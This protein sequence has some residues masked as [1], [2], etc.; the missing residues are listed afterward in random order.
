MTPERP[1]SDTKQERV[2]RL[3]RADI[4]SGVLRDGAVL[5]SSRVLAEQMGV[6]VYTIAKAMDLLES[7]GLIVN[8]NRSRRMV[9]SRFPSKTLSEPRVF[10]VGGYAGSG[11][12]ELGRILARITGLAVVDKDTITRPVVET[13]LEVLGQPSYDR[14]SAIYLDQVRPREY[15][16]LLSSVFENAEVGIGVIATA[17][18]IRELADPAWIERTSATI[19]QAGLALTII[20]VDCDADT[21]HTY[22]RRRGAARDTV[23]LSNWAAYLDA[24]DLDF[25]PA[26]PHVVIENSATSEPLQSQAVRLLATLNGS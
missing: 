2:A 1:A 11:K 24:L 21:M 14:E 15:E 13:A 16:A 9:K 6:S 12:S 26:A 7:E 25:R 8:V 10:L 3:V 5:P 20:W 19:A 23:K 4:E 22:V 17:P 18:F